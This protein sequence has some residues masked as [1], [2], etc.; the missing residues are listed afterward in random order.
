MGSAFW[1]GAVS[2][3]DQESPPG[4]RVARELMPSARRK[5]NARRARVAAPL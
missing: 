2:P 4:A 5:T 3:F 1:G